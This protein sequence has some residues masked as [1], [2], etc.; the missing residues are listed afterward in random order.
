MKRN[1]MFGILVLF[2]IV[3]T[4]SISYAQSQEGIIVIDYT[5]GPPGSVGFQEVLQTGSPA[6]PEDGG[7]IGC[8]LIDGTASW[9]VVDGEGQIIRIGQGTQAEQVS[10]GAQ[11][12]LSVEGQNCQEVQVDFTIRVDSFLGTDSAVDGWRDI[13]IPIRG[14]F[15]QGSGRFITEVSFLLDTQ[16][17]CNGGGSCIGFVQGAIQPIRRLFGQVA[18]LTLYFEAAM[19]GQPNPIRSND[20]TVIVPSAAEVPTVPEDTSTHGQVIIDTTSLSPKTSTFR[21]STTTSGDYDVAFGYGSDIYSLQFPEDGLIWFKDHTNPFYDNPERSSHG[22]YCVGSIYLAFGNT[23]V[24]TSDDKVIGTTLITSNRQSEDGI[25]FN[26]KVRLGANRVKAIRVRGGE[27][28]F[29]VYQRAEEEDSGS[30]PT[31]GTRLDNNPSRSELSSQGYGSLY[32]R[33]R[34]STDIT[35]GT[36]SQAIA[37]YFET[38]K[39]AQGRL[40]PQRNSHRE[41][42]SGFQGFS[43][44]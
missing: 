34:C 17:T 44:S 23:L 24:T 8:T 27:E 5:N 31:R 39:G 35:L 30:N 32:S 16:L 3:F 14:D 29:F 13:T 28:Y 6:P 25:F 11:V 36:D 4:L 37:D 41:I 7:E 43:E 9:V 18:T 2:L 15:N 33:G 38:L 1:I 20:I 12:Y 40:S 22:N 21:L 26:E 19:Q 10:S 42:S